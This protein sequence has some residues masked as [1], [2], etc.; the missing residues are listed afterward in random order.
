MERK[1]PL[2]PF[3][4]ERLIGRGGMAEVWS[5]YHQSGTP[6]AVKVLTGEKTRSP[7]YVQAFRREVRAM[8]GLHHPSIVHVFDYGLI[9]H[10][11]AHASGGYLAPGS[12]FLVME[13][14]EGGTLQDH[15][16]RLPWPQLK[17]IL[18]E[19]LEA[20]AHAHASGVIHRDL[21]PANVLLRKTA[22]YVILTDFGLA[23]AVDDDAA[24][25]Q[26]QRAIG[27]TPFMAP[28]QFLCAWRDYGP[29]TDMYALGCLVYTMV[30]NATPFYD[31]S[32]YGWRTAHFMS[33][34]P[35]LYPQMFVPEK[36][37]AWVHKLMTKEPQLRYQRAV[38]ALWD[39][40]CMEGHTKIPSFD[41]L[42]A[43]TPPPSLAS[44]AGAGLSLPTVDEDSL[45]LEAT[46]EVIRSAQGSGP[47]RETQES[48]HTLVG[49]E[50]P[51]DPIQELRNIWMSFQ[52]KS[53]VGQSSMLFTRRPSLPESWGEKVQMV[54]SHLMGAG[55]GLYGLRTIPMVDRDN[56][57]KVL[58]QALGEVQSSRQARMVLLEG[59]SGYGKS[60]LGE[61]LSVTAHKASGAHILKAFH[62]PISGPRDGL[63]SMLSRS[64]RCVGLTRPEVYLRCQL[65]LHNLGVNVA[66]EALALTELLC[67]HLHEEVR[68]P[69]LPTVRFFNPTERYAVIRYFLEGLTQH[70]PVVVWLDD[71]Q[72]GV[73]TLGFCQYL[74]QSQDLHPMPVLL[75]ATVQH[76]AL[77]TR[78]AEQIQLERLHAMESVSSVEV[79]PLPEE[80]RGELVHELL[81]LEPELAQLVV[82]RTEGNPLFAVQLVGDWVSRG[83]LVSGEQ[84]FGLRS[85]NV[86]AFLPDSLH[87]LWASRV[88]RV[89][90]GTGSTARSSLELAALL[91]QEVD[92]DEWKAVCSLAGFTASFEL[93]EQLLHTRL[94]T[95]H[96]EGPE[97]G[98]SFVHGMLRESLERGCKEAGRWDSAHRICAQM[99][100]ERPGGSATERRGLHLLA[101]GDTDE[102]ISLLLTAAYE[103]TQTGDYLV[104]VQVLDT[105]EDTLV[106][107]DIPP[108][109]EQWG[110]CWAYRSRLVQL[111]GEY[112]LGAELASKAI[113][114]GRLYGWSQALA[115]ALLRGGNASRILG[116]PDAL[117]LLLEAETLFSQL[118]KSI[119]LGHTRVVKGYQ[120]MKSGDFDGALQSA[121]KALLDFGGSK[122]PYMAATCHTLLA[123]I[124]MHTS[125]LDGAEGY[126]R[127]ALSLY[128]ECGS[129]W[130]V[131]CSLNGLGEMARLNKRWEEAEQAYRDALSR[132]L[133][134]GSGSAIFP[135]FNLGQLL[136]IR[137]SYEEA[138]DVLGRTL[139]RVRQQGRKNLSISVH[140]SLLACAA[141]RGKWP[142][143]ESHFFQASAL[144]EATQYVDVDIPIMAEIAGDLAV[145]AGQ[146]PRAC[147]IYALAIKQWHSLQQPENAETLNKKLTQLK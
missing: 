144:L 38:E 90:D 83:M 95:C 4:L 25:M 121:K 54:P 106:K 123:D 22:P 108:E 12:P 56:E 89:L 128:E 51:Q 61:W 13:L 142:D 116:R 100:A 119:K 133:A 40:Q 135:Q 49:D 98:W 42:T 78:M 57:R 143:W 130:G 111:Q 11:A 46:P 66:G 18:Q 50:A 93:V 62:S 16:G 86:A 21:K 69:S 45:G 6:V 118:G 15:V 2:G 73:D 139:H 39:L 97:V 137:R 55:L 32:F 70:R 104:G 109:N 105:C 138:E 27:T 129:R 26:E 125:R 75:V 87:E 99:L 1:I 9:P 68:D 58:W 117:E 92:G 28:E 41:D 29:W 19:L 14:A 72:W 126:I 53:S 96:E 43:Q 132:Y 5:G 101:A 60:R 8:A 17:Y 112:V 82:E 10:Q 35:P 67:Q 37:E 30:S 103:Y 147:S 47:V 85:E 52:K 114:A 88:E 134:I 80:Y 63:E 7:L 131:A 34:L 91:G 24:A 146:I 64:I 136:V 84:G 107:R 127:K 102:A 140:V 33:P 110:L 77:Q 3:V 36:L 23:H 65:L 120:L 59:M 141:G 71:V 76:E 48:Q 122:S 20:L 124:H 94:A 113:V 74:L 145:E 44:L 115:E 79:A 31:Q 81:G